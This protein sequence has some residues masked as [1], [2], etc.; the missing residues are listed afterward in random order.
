MTRHAVDLKT[1]LI[2]HEGIRL[3][4]YTDTVGKLTIGVGRNL[5]DKGI[6]HAEALAML[7][8][9]IADATN[10]CLHEFPW[11]VGLT[12]PRKW[13]ILSMVFNLGLEGLKKFKRMLA[14]VELEDYQ[15]AAWE[16][17]QSKWA[18]QVGMRAV[19]L[20]EMMRGH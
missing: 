7:D 10:D 11:F 9:D 16:M 17:A 6:T 19:E 15:G 1:L 2:N 4:P 14:C 5:A 8:K 12:E 18:Q 13:V 3:K 20:Q